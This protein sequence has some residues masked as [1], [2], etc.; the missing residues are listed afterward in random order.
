[1]AWYGLSAEVW[2]RLWSEKWKRLWSEKGSKNN[3]CSQM[4]LEHYCADF[5]LAIYQAH[6]IRGYDRKLAKVF[7][8]YDLYDRETHYFLKEN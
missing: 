5:K 1:M 6:T 4:N 3:Q 2:K 7:Q 8:S